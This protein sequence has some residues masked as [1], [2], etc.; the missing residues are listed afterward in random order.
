MLIIRVD[1]TN[2]NVVTRQIEKV[3]QDRSFTA[4][5]QETSIASLEGAPDLE[6]REVH[7]FGEFGHDTEILSSNVDFA[8]NLVY[9]DIL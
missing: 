8:D 7:N 3:H 1:R 9:S 5:D 2:F 4:G 6:E